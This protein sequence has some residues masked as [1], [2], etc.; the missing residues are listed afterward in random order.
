MEAIRSTVTGLLE[1]SRYN[2]VILPQLHE[3][4]M[5][6]VNDGW[7]DLDMNLATLKLYQF[8][9]EADVVDINILCKI[10]AKALMNLPESDFQLCMYLVPS[11]LLDHELVVSLVSLAS[12]LE[13]AKFS[14]FWSELKEKPEVVSLAPGLEDAIRTF[15]FD[16][17]GLTYA[18]VPVESL[19][20]LVSLRGPQLDK[21][22]L[23][24]GV[25]CKGGIAYMR[26]T[27]ENQSKAF[28]SMAD[29]AQQAQL[30]AILGALVV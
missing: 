7:Y 17:V 3:A 21:A 29:S 28:V 30:P 13:G 4:V 14:Q 24:H 2:K 5:S 18:Q 25:E 8:H 12:K 15:I 19:A 1:T 23:A 27:E 10:L 22:M 6:Q 20:Q 26:K 11:N 9:P 16:T